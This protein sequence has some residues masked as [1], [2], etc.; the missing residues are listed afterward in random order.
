MRPL[1]TDS[2]FHNQNALNNGKVTDNFVIGIHNTE[3]GL[4]K[5][6]RGDKYCY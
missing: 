6:D 1:S 3:F 5:T 4:T 2:D